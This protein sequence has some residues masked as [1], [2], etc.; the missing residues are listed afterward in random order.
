L[1][2]LFAREPYYPRVFIVKALMI[3]RLWNESLGHLEIG[4]RC[5]CASHGVLEALP[6]C[7]WQADFIAV[8]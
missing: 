5:L 4:I 8:R 1:P 6:A 7:K 3:D 2:W